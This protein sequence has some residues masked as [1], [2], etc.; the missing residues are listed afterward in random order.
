MQVLA[1]VGPGEPVGGWRAG[2]L[3]GSERCKP[4]GRQRPSRTDAD[5]LLQKKEKKEKSS[6]VV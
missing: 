4:Q 5:L 2:P 1:E 3:P 6:L